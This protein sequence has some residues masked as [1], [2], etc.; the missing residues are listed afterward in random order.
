MKAA[1]AFSGGGAR[2]VLQA[3]VLQAA[4]ESGIET[5]EIT[6]TSAGAIVAVLYADGYSPAEICEIFRSTRRRTLFRPV[7]RAGG[8][9]GI[10]GTEKNL[11]KLLRNKQLE[12]LRFPVGVSATDIGKME[13]VFFRQGDIARAVAAASALPVFFEAVKIGPDY[14]LDGGLLNNLPVEGL[15]GNFPI[16][17]LHSNAVFPTGKL[18]GLVPMA[19]R[20]FR[21]LAWN[22]V[23]RRAEKCRLFINPPETAKYS[24]FDFKKAPE[25]Y[26]IGYKAG[27]KA[28]PGLVE[29]LGK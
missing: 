15:S 6:A 16:I 20:V 11:D 17:G 25:I 3:G 24:I 8:L 4:E 13:T 21:I 1:W 12:D 19:E 28:L 5:A 2:A 22:N 23:A 9:F 26:R 7:L 18:P 14:F 10:G 29:E 27:L